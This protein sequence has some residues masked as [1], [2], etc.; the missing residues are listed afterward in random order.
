MRRIRYKVA[1]SLDGFIAR[2]N[3]EVDWIIT[4]PEIDFGTIFAQFDTLLIGRRTF[5]MMARAGRASTPGMKTYVFS[6]SLQATDYPQVTIVAENLNDVVASIKAEPGKDIWVFGGGDLFRS[7]L[8]AGLVDTVEIAVIPVLIGEGIPLVPV[9][10]EDAKLKLIG[11]Q[12]F[13]KTGIVWL[14]YAITSPT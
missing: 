12:V 9:P 7:L 14:E 6:R 2:P 13:S 8:N 3:G 1:A 5:E 10:S 11:H 4:D